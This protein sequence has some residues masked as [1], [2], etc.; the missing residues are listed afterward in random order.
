M[1]Y[2]VIWTEISNYDKLFTCWTCDQKIEREEVNDQEEHVDHWTQA[3]N[4]EE[5]EALYNE[6]ID[7]GDKIVSCSIVVPIK[8][9]DF[10]EVVI[11]V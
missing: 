8:S 11:N 2:I 6:L 5:A 7:G 10:E 3:D 1:Q 4:F 9:T